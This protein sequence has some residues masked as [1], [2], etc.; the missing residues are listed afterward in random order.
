[1]G[2]FGRRRRRRGGGGGHPLEREG[3]QRKGQ[4]GCERSEGV[5]GC[6]VAR[7]EGRARWEEAGGVVEVGVGMRLMECAW[8][9]RS[10]G[11]RALRKRQRHLRP[12][13]SGGGARHGRA[14]LSIT[15]RCCQ[16]EPRRR[17]QLSVARSL[18]RMRPF[19]SSR[20]AGHGLQASR[21]KGKRHGAHDISESDDPR[22]EMDGES[23]GR[24]QGDEKTAERGGGG[25]GR[26]A[27]RTEVQRW[28]ERERARAAP[29]RYWPCGW[30]T[31]SKRSARPAAAPSQ[32]VGGLP[33]A[34]APSSAARTSADPSERLLAGG[35]W[36]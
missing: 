33:P 6:R 5:G 1:M 4:A 13:P 34:P 19:E 29:I 9:N 24:G 7:R 15:K 32:A 18:A 2:P 25:Q 22:V 35:D 10:A 20:T 21:R 31:S 17:R 12:R 23:E 28:K 36:L 27:C 11:S 16:R 14:S 26:P 8:A 30:S 3:G